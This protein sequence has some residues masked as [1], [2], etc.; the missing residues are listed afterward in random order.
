MHEPTLRPS[1]RVR[2]HVAGAVLLPLLASNAFAQ[3]IAPQS[4]DVAPTVA[5]TSDV[6]PRDA[7]TTPTVPAPAADASVAGPTLLG[8]TAA[9]RPAHPTRELATRRIASDDRPHAGRA[10]ALM[11]TGAAGIVVG[12]I[13]GG[14]AEA[15]LV[16]GGAVV[17]LIGLYDWVK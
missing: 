6:T 5:F 7:A 4:A 3:T 1:A 14:D 13:A 2:L 17:G 9:A 12:L 11:I 10:A 15:P 8:A 16:V